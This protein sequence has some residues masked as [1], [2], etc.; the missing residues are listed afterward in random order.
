MSF[1]DGYDKYD[2][3]KLRCSLCLLFPLPK[4]GIVTRF[5]YGL[6]V[7]FFTHLCL[8]SSVASKLYPTTLIY[9]VHTCIPRVL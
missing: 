3:H 6:G 1:H 2:E 7:N 9:Y 5:H 8:I 4:L